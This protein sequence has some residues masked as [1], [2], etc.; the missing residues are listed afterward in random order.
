MSRLS[1]NTFYNLAGRILIIVISVFTA[2]YIHDKL[3]KDV[4]G[5]IQFAFFVNMLLVTTL[6]NGVC[7]MIVREISARLKSEPDYISNLIRTGS[8]FFWGFYLIIAVALYFLAPVLTD[9]WINL[10]SLDKAHAIYMLRVIGISVLLAL[11]TAFY[12][13]MLNGLQRME[14]PNLIDLGIS[15]VQ[16]LGVIYILLSHGSFFLVIN[17][18]A[19]CFAA[20]LAAAALVCMKFFKP[21]SLVPGFSMDVI[22]RNL[23][24]TMNLMSITVT[25]ALNIH[26]DRIILSK[27]LPISKMGYYS[28]TVNNL[29]QAQ[30]ISSAVNQAAYPVFSELYELKDRKGMMAQYVKLQDFVCFAL[31]P[32]MAAV[33]FVIPPLFRFM[34]GEKTAKMMFLPAILLAIAMYMNGTLSIPN[35]FSYAVGKPGI[36]ARMNFYALFISIPVTIA[37]IYFFGLVGAGFSRIFYWVFAYT[38]GMP[39]ICKQ[40]LFT[41]VS[42][43]YY[44]LLKIFLLTGLTYGPAWY[45]QNALGG[46][47]I[48]SLAIGY[49]VATIAFA[50][51]AYFMICSGLRETINNHLNM[52]RGRTAV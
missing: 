40:C 48:A 15:A 3:G 17:W 30:L 5:V 24:F 46:G 43:W 9:R 14:F 49:S 18:Y 44:H 16:Q 51:V 35:T 45:I 47:S 50:I 31:A 32:V 34:F 28:F 4:W 42:E 20:K 27:L 1:K 41:P 36:A 8:L 25:G 13:S 38:Y 11:P 39:R 12:I 26:T 19:G 10:E 22:K 37:L 2:K 29:G 21:G 33:P 6:A 7:V 52:L 23:R